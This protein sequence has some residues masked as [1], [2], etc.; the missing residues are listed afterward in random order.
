MNAYLLLMCICEA[1]Q[2]SNQNYFHYKCTDNYS[3]VK[4][5]D[6]IYVLDKAQGKL[7]VILDRK[8][9]FNCFPKSIFIYLLFFVINMVL[10]TC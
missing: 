9:N 7:L 8:F 10:Y 2:E 3:S 1:V 6:K 5:L 4:K